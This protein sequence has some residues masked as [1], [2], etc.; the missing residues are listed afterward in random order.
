MRRLPRHH[1]TTT[2][3]GRIPQHPP[4]PARPL[5]HPHRRP[6]R[7]RTPPQNPHTAR[8]RTPGHAP[9]Q[10]KNTS[11]SCTS[12]YSSSASNSKPN[13][14]SA[15]QPNK[16]PLTSDSSSACSTH[17]PHQNRPLRYDDAGSNA[18]HCSRACTRATLA[19]ALIYSASVVLAQTSEYFPAV[20]NLSQIQGSHIQ[21]QNDQD[22]RSE[23]RAVVPKRRCENDDDHTG[24]E[25]Y[26]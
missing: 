22:C 26:P 17:N 12:K 25:T 21:Q 24:P 2:S 16:T 3:S 7:R 15:K 11:P 6:H 13:R 14:G 4:R 23:Q 19:A 10:T 18:E 20:P 9:G 8:P 1:Q 5:A